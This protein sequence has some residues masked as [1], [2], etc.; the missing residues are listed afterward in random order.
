MKKAYFIGIA[1]RTMGALAK[2]LKDLGW[3]V[4]GSDR[5]GIYPPMSIFLKENGLAYFEGYEEKNVPL[6]ADLVVV[7]YSPLLIDANNPEYLM[8]KKLGLKVVSYPEVLKD[9]L[10]KENS[11]VVAGT[12]GKTTITL[13]I[14]WILT[15]SGKN[16][17]F[18]SGG[19]SPDLKDGVKITDSAWSV[20]EGDEVPS[21]LKADPPKF[22]FYRPKYLVLTATKWDHPEIYGDEESYLSA[23]KKLIERLPEDGLL[24]YNPDSVNNDLVQTA[25]CPKVSYS[26]NNSSTD[27][28]IKSYSHNDNKTSFELNKND[29]ASETLLLGKTNLENICAAIATAD[30]LKIDKKIINQAIASFRGVKIRLEYLGKLTG[31]YF[32]SDFAQHPEKV[33]GSLTALR[34][35]YPKNRIICIYDPSATGLKYR[36]ILDWFEGV[37]DNADQIIIGKVGFL[38][39]IAKEE[40]VSGHDLVKAIY[41]TQKNVFYEP[42]DENILKWLIENSKEDNVIVFMSSGGL[43]FTSLIG[44]II[45]NFKK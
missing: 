34:E 8:A 27:Y 22:M 17:C 19:I 15:C 30:Q 9:L 7:G 4:L 1:G 42:T 36:K 2:A 39:S 33:K 44:K 24:V 25:K 10:I 45:R 32:Y 21:L 28:Y 23:F 35:H 18:M 6:D 12:Y 11:I 20:V 31:K 5:K 43:K 29:I 38:K 3:Q 41:K 40:R 16:P 14:S 26:L 37:F 13:L